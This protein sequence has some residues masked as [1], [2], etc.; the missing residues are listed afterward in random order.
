MPIQSVSQ[1]AYLEARLTKEE[2]DLLF[3]EKLYS[4]KEWKEGVSKQIKELLP[5][6]Y[7]N[8]V[9]TECTMTYS[10]NAIKSA[11]TGQTYNPEII[12]AILIAARRHQQQLYLLVEEP[13][14]ET[15]GKIGLEE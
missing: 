11:A 3:P 1:R 13:I 10:D 8:K 14:E 9:R 2:F 4:Y 15:T 7:V 12:L 5:A 6:I